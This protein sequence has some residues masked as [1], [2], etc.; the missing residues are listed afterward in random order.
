MR[1]LFLGWGGVLERSGGGL[2]LV[3]TLVVFFGGYGTDYVVC[4]APRRNA[5]QVSLWLLYA[6]CQRTL[7]PPLSMQHAN[8]SPEQPKSFLAYNHH[9]P[10]KE[11]SFRKVKYK[12]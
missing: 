11:K 9:I 10:K 12:Q 5:S 2:V 7:E 6:L 1:C 3:S 4:V 8:P